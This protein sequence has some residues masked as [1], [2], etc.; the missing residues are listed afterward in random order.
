[1]SVIESAMGL[2]KPVSHMLKLMKVKSD[3]ESMDESI[4]IQVASDAS[5]KVSGQ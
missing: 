4:D 2:K 5:M 1:M 3:M